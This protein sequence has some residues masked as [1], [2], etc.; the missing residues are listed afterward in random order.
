[1][2]RQSWRH[3]AIEGWAFVLIAVIAFAGGFLVGDLGGSTKTETVTVS[4]PSSEKEAEGAEPTGTSAEGK[5]LFTSVGCGSCHTMSAAGATGKVG[6]DLEKSL[7]VDDNAAGIEEMIIHPNAE[8]IE[9]YPPNV[10][11]QDYGQTLSSEEVH[12]VAEF[13][14]ANSPAKP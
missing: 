8:V 12:A 10:M 3:L 14:V 7:A 11:P 1:V 2:Q 13:L 9:G 5:Q 6:P 4:A